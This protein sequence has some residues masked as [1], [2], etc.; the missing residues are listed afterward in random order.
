MIFTRARSTFRKLISYNV[1]QEFT[2][3][4]VVLCVSLLSRD[5]SNSTCLPAIKVLFSCRY[6]S[7]FFCFSI[8]S[9]FF[10]ISNS[11]FIFSLF[12]PMKRKKV[13]TL[14][15]DIV[16]SSIRL[17]IT[18]SIIFL[19][20]IINLRNFLKTLWSIPRFRIVAKSQRV[21]SLLICNTETGLMITRLNYID[22]KTP[23]KVMR[24]S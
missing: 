18:Y 3:T 6:F 16:L 12:Q 20:A 14:F 1:L 9:I 15:I 19:A 13:V 22:A 7:S 2:L 17:D 21:V 4:D 23:K 8:V 24:T 5:A 10:S 11:P